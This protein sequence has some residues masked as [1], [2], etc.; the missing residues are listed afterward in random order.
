MTLISMFSSIFGD[1]IFKIWNSTLEKNPVTTIIFA[2]FFFLA[3]VAFL[4]KMLVTI[5]EESFDCIKMRKNY[6]WLDQKLSVQ[7]YI[8]NEI[9][10]KDEDLDKQQQGHHYMM[11]DIVLNL[12]L[13]SNCLIETIDK[14][15]IDE[16]VQIDLEKLE[17]EGLL[18]D[19]VVKMIK[20]QFQKSMKYENLND[21]EEYDLVDEN[22]EVQKVKNVYKTIDNIFGK[23]MLSLDKI[24][25]VVMR[26]KA[27]HSEIYDRRDSNIFLK[28]LRE[29]IN[30]INLNINNV[31]KMFK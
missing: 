27:N 30:K 7:D 3:F 24:N 6:Y 14:S 20:K 18:R 29:N 5:T 4:M 10:L 28:R 1:T 21:Q 16:A 22:L 9:V 17:S 19:E 8:K 12:I 25:S 13:N 26:Q 31:K 15:S 11:S 23:I 2:L